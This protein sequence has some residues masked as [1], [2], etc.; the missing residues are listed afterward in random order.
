[1]RCAACW[2]CVAMY[3]PVGIGYWMW[4][5]RREP[6]GLAARP[7]IPALIAA[8]LAVVM[9]MGKLFVPGKHPDPTDVLIAMVAAAGAYLLATQMHRWALQG[10][11]RAAGCDASRRAGRTRPRA[12]AS[13]ARHGTSLASFLL[14]CGAGIASVESPARR[15]LARAG[16]RRRMPPCCGA[17]P[18]ICLPA[19]LALLP[20]LDFSP[21]SGWILLNEFDLLMAV[22]LA[23]RLLRPPPD[24]A[25]VRHCPAAPGWPIGLLAAS[26]FA[27]AVVGL[28]PL[29]P[30]DPNALGSYYSGFNSLRQSEGLRLGAG[31]A[32][33]ADRG[34]ARRSG[35]WSEDGW[36]A[37][38]PDCA[39]CCAVV[40]WERAAF[41]GLLDF[42]GEYRAE[43]TFPELHTGGGDVHAYLVMAIPFVVAWIGLRPSA[44]RV[45]LPER[46]CS[47]WRATRSR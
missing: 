28:L 29:S 43:G 36:R 9:E 26:F 24:V 41:A 37:C 32:A 19:V 6:G 38:S 1:M 7:L 25:R 5:L 15:R 13:P 3:L 4:T 34:G 30:F 14:L 10:E 46:R 44:F 2:P 20:L 42:A 11:P 31:V 35:A 47:C 22:T 45:A 39:A 18:A 12:A 23:V 33:A 16:A 40:L 21:W 17:I 27:S 8:P